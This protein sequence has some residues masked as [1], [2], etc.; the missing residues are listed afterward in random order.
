MLYFNKAQLQDLQTCFSIY[1]GRLTDKLITI[2]ESG[3]P[4]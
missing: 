3:K 1:F 4:N 2:D